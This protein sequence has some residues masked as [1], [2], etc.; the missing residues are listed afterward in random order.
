[1]LEDNAAQNILMGESETVSKPYSRH[2]A[3]FLPSV[4]AEHK[5]QG[6]GAHAE[7]SKFDNSTGMPP[8]RAADSL[9]LPHQDEA[10]ARIHAATVAVVPKHQQQH[11]TAGLQVDGGTIQAQV[12]RWRVPY[13]KT[14]RGSL[15]RSNRVGPDVMAAALPG[16][17]IG[18]V[19]RD[20]P[21]KR[22]ALEIDRSTD[23]Q[24][25]TELSN[26]GKPSSLNPYKRKKRN[27][28]SMQRMLRQSIEQV[29]ACTEE[30]HRQKLQQQQM[31]QDMQAMKHASVAMLES[32]ISAA[33]QEQQVLHL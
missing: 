3:Q 10:S 5:H 11:E 32:A 12:L 16:R 20:L 1:M 29:H 24:G 6:A 15:L 19:S 4:L 31:R 13:S 21:G 8:S 27:A 22:A 30:L 18:A 14:R 33:L 23:R 9:H 2:T 28:L 17:S 26:L 7:T 25:V